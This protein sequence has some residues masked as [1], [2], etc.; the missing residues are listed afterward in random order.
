M[1][2]GTYGAASR[3]SEIGLIGL[4]S[5]GRGI[6]KNLI[7]H[8]FPLTV[9]DAN[10]A[11]VEP[12]P[13]LGAEGVE[14]PRAVAERSDVV[15][16]VLPNGPDVEAVAFGPDGV[17]EGA[18][19]GTIL[20]DCSTIDPSVSRAIG[21][22]L[23]ER[24]VRMVDAGDGALLGGGRRGHAAV[25]GRREPEDFEVIEP[26]LDATRQRRLPR[27]AA[28]SRDHAEDRPQPALAD[29]AGRQ[30]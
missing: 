7:K 20:M 23:A 17:V 27:R 13:V 11:A 25:H 5:M 15:V 2:G 24:G 6:G 21:A 22:A 18:Q 28:R 10:L 16:T 3:S 1:R 30:R 26:L 9:Y 12:L 4:G 29:D 19:P 8:G 14:S